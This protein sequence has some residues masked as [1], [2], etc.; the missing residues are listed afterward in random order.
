MHARFLLGPAGTGKTFLCLAEIREAL[1]ADPSGPPLILLAPRQATFQLERQLLGDP[2]LQGY[3]RLQILS[4]Q[5][6]ADLVLEQAGAA[7][8][9]LLSE[10]GRSMVLRTVLGRRRKDLEIF[11]SSAGMAGFARQLSLDLRELQRRKLSPDSLRALAER[12]DLGESLRRKLRDLSLLLTDYLAWLRDHNLQ[13]ADCL[14]DL[15]A[16]AL[17]RSTV[18][19]VAESLWLD[20]FAE[21]TPQELDLLAVVASRCQKLTLAFCLENIPA[22]SSSSWLSI[23]AGIE[24]TF[25]QCWAKLSALPGARLTTEI[26]PRQNHGRFK[27]SPALRHLEAKWTVPT[28]FNGGAPGESLRAV[29]CATPASEA[30]LAAQEI[31]RFVRAGGRFREV[32]V[33]LRG[34]EDHQDSLRRVFVRYDIP[35]FMDRRE[36]VS[37]HPLAELTRSVVRAAAFGWQ[38]DDWFGVLKTGLVAADEEN[39]DRLEN[40]ALARGWS[41]DAWFAPLP[42]D[43]AK[44]DWP[45]RLR[46]KWIGPFAKFR[47]LVRPTGPELAGALRQLWLDLDV[48]KTLEDWSAAEG[49]SGAVH[50]TIWRQLNTW[51]DDLTLAFAEEPMS[52][53]EWLPILDLG[54]AELSVGV[55]P[56]ALDQVLI[57]TIDRSRN[58]DLKLVILLGV[59]ETMFPATPPEGSL[60][61]ESDR[62]ELGRQEI[63]L[64]HSRREFL[65]RERF[66]GYIACTRS[67][68]RLV[69]ACSE[70]NNDDQPLNPSPFY[71]HLR[72]L[73]ADLQIEKFSGADWTQAKHPCELSGQLAR[74]GRHGPLLTELLNRPC[75]CRV[76]RTD[77]D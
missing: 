52:M 68:Q 59:N 20:G 5:R 12:A 69:V 54:L 26:L 66:F 74:A 55:I 6:L 25:R 22:T 19:L 49:K 13:D 35:F 8:P 70:R 46:K 28:P 47:R 76:A 16:D 14:L 61:N 24:N 63:R 27:D 29:V 38:H 15:A 60:L 73:F 51:L 45:E 32:A 42:A 30:V 57:G 40:E 7:I 41:G 18:P 43:N 3:T 31:L 2:A 11:H 23:W 39:I 67:R 62:E 44:S 4:F 58:P 50:A 65:G 48:E 71:S 72:S 34:M 64:G 53:T 77:R 10:D 21:M 36:K 75:L 56:P 37:Q 1:R 33:L 17:K 9:P